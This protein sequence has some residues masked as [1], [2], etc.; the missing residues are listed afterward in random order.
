MAEAVIIDAVRT[1][2]GVRDGGLA[3]WHP[4][5]LA[6]HVLA[7]LVERSQLDPEQIEEVVLGC[8]TQ[9]GAQSSNLARGAVL[10]GGMPE[11]I[12]AATVD[13]QA[14]SSQHAVMIAAHAI[15]AG[16]YDIAIAGGVEVM[17][18]V[19]ARAAGHEP[20]FGQAESPAMKCRYTD[21]GGLVPLPITAELLAASAGLD[22]DQL[23]SFAVQS[24][25]RAAAAQAEGRF[26]AEI[27]PVRRRPFGGPDRSDSPLVTADE[28][29]DPDLTI[30]AL[31]QLKPIFV[32]GGMVTPGN[33]ARVADGASATL[34]MS[35]ERAAALGLNPRARLR[36]FA[37]AGVDPILEFSGVVAAT[38]KALEASKLSIDDIDCIEINESFA[39][40]VLAWAA[41]L[42]PDPAR[43]NANGGAIALGHPAGCAGTRLLA[44]LL[45]ELDRSGG[46]FGLQTMA[47]AGG[48]ANATIIERIA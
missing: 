37:T 1:P 17:S 48:L 4:A 28:G 40:T 47:A 6:G 25:T 2:I 43:V 44:S 29:V 35:E 19:P 20:R 27:V 42:H 33:A 8:A 3:G 38:R 11:S 31:A 10:A 5:D 12:S 14:A 23:D 41:E 39:S 13:R 26:D 30:D 34:I 32:R 36:T 7:A 46:R 45:A 15:M 18:R 9:V 16:T 24:H 21:S 22:R